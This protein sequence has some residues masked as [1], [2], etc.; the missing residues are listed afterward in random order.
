[1]RAKRLDATAKTV[2]E[3][4]IEA[5]KFCTSVGE[6][7]ILEALNHLARVVEELERKVTVLSL[8]PVPA[9]VPAPVA[10]T[11]EE[12]KVLVEATPKEEKPAKISHKSVAVKKEV[13]ASEAKAE[14]FKEVSA[15]AKADQPVVE[16]P[17]EEKK[18]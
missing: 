15:S 13:K 16:K 11:D 6:K 3:D 17:K 9:P 12:K 18:I 14:D 5:G 7:H 8:A 1:M 10:S 4:C 2:Q